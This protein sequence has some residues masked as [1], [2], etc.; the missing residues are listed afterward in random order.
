MDLER[1]TKEKSP[2]VKTKAK[3]GPKKKK[4][5]EFGGEKKKLLADSDKG[6]WFDQPS[7]IGEKRNLDM[8][9]VV[10]HPKVWWESVE[11]NNGKELARRKKGYEKATSKHKP[12]L[13]FPRDFMSFTSASLQ[14]HVGTC[15]SISS[16][17]FPKI[18][19]F[20]FSLLMTTAEKRAC[21]KR[22]QNYSF[23][24]KLLVADCERRGFCYFIG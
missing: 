7:Q 19:L 16:F 10:L 24:A 13:F 1:F 5:G 12:G 6:P 14:S 9:S 15:S 21:R 23:P 22:D 2:W 4:S 11:K 18:A 17:F 3:T 20:L 8:N